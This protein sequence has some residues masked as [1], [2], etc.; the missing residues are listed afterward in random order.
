MCKII[1][2]TALHSQRFHIS[3][4]LVKLYDLR[5][6]KTFHS[7]WDQIFQKVFFFVFDLDFIH[8][9]NH[10][11]YQSQFKCSN[12]LK[13]QNFL[14]LILLSQINQNFDYLMIHL[15]SYYFRL[16]RLMVL[17]SLLHILLQFFL[18]LQLHS[19]LLLLIYPR[20]FDN[21][22]QSKPFLLLMA[23]AQEFKPNNRYCSR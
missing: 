1:F 12:Y 8:H 14:N 10:L 9:Q 15:E 11:S 3:A 6:I 21:P 13:Y 2:L 17:L 16:S 19:N 23:Q 22:L 7:L 4:Q 20:K 5:V 18:L